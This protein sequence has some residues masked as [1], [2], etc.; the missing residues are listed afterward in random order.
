MFYKCQSVVK[1]LL[2]VIYSKFK[3]IQNASNAYIHCLSTTRKKKKDK[4]LESTKSF[5]RSE[6]L[7]VCVTVSV[8]NFNIEEF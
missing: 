7:N 3:A 1:T 8:F 4:L 2:K 6:N 5:F